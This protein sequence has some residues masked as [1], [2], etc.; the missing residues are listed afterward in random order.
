MALAMAKGVEAELRDIAGNKVCVDC[1]CRGPQWASVTFGVFMCLECSG[2]HRS[3]GVHISFVRSVAMDSWTQDQIQL[4]RLG[5]NEKCNSFLSKYNA[6]CKKANGKESDIHSKY[7]SAPAC[8]Y[9]D[10]LKAEVEGKPL[11]TE[12][13][14]VTNTGSGGSEPVNGETEAA[15][16]ARQ[17]RQ[18]EEASQRMREKF[19]K[20]GGLGGSTAMTGIGSDANY[21]PG[22]GG[23]GGSSE[24]GFSMPSLGSLGINDD[25]TKKLQEEASKALDS[26]WSFFGSAAAALGDTVNSVAANVVETIDP[27]KGAEGGAD[28]GIFPRRELK[29]ASTGKMSGVGGG[30]A[31]EQ[32]QDEDD[33]LGKNLEWMKSGALDFW[34]KAT[35]A[36][37]EFAK[38]VQGGNDNFGEDDVFS[39]RNNLKGKSTGKM[40]H[41]GSEAYMPASSSSIQRNTSNGSMNS[42]GNSSGNGSGNGSGGIS[43]KNS[44]SNSL[45]GSIGGSTE[46]LAASGSA[47]GSRAK[48]LSPAPSDDDFFNSFGVK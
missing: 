27:N 37:S 26:T 24:M 46:N 2:T 42:Y 36:T 5:G 20:T 16:V 48:K 15:Y 11:P 7:N 31:P 14:K 34:N 30:E 8:L 18:R 40:D 19:G 12:L 43:S 33:E 13:P 39:F 32:R 44:S 23:G 9:K 45:N 4:M 47:P 25:S 38:S 1:N 10:R 35:D 17:A 41:T 21:R 29:G 22:G 6:L 3:L 28:D